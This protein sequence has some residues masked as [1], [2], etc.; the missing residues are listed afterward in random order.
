[1]LLVF[2]R[3]VGFMGK[4]QAEQLLHNYLMEGE[5]WICLLRF[6]ESKV[7]DTQSARVSA[8]P[9]LTLGYIDNGK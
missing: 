6:R 8:T 3:I 9:T 4:G 1:M 2:S 7:N 5:N